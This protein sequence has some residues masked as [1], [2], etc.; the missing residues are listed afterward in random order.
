MDPEVAGSMWQH[1]TAKDN[2]GEGNITDSRVK[3]AIALT[4][5]VIAA[6]ALV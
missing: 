2:R 6:I 4:K 3:A 5:I 1:S